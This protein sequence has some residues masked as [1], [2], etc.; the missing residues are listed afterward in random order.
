MSRACLAIKASALAA[1]AFIGGCSDPTDAG[2]TGPTVT[3]ASSARAASTSSVSVSGT[4]P[5]DGFQA[6]TLDVTVNGSGFDSGA[7]ATFP[8]N[9]VVDP[10]VHVNSTRY[11]K[12]T[13]LVANVTIAPDAPTVTYD[14]AVLDGSGKKGIGSELFTVNV[15]PP[16]DPAIAYGSRTTKGS[17]V[18][19]GL[20]VMNAD[21]T[22]QTVI[23]ASGYA[24]HP[25]WS[26][27]GHSIAY[28]V[29]TYDISRVDVSIVNGVPQAS[30][31]VTLPI[32]HL[33]FDIAWSPDASNPQVAYSESPVN[34]GDQV[35]VYLAP[36]SSVS[37][38]VE[39]QIYLGPPN[40]R[41][42]WIA[43]NPQATKIALIQR[44][45]AVMVDSLFVIDVA[46]KTATFVREF[47][48]GVFGL[49]WSRT[50]PDRLALSVPRP[51]NSLQ[52]SILDLTTNTLSNASGGE[53]AKWSPDDSRLVYVSPTNQGTNP[54]YVVT[55]STG[56]QVKLTADGFEPEWRRNP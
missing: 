10:R 18:T 15:P 46:T 4:I 40:N 21:G 16:A 55:L 28:H 35:G 5:S 22:N 50:A 37:P 38:Y 53:A 13:Q 32:T 26:P 33:C 3:S 20:G 56:V 14:V 2:R 7:T 36:A 42:I 1:A 6:M 34:M 19:Y 52:P 24:P 29:G 41:M 9:G 12:S 54:I 23:A 39:T 30:A 31:P 51:D 45:V 11:V 17:T 25:A 43:W 27:D 49:S 8:L 48:R 47:K 44:S